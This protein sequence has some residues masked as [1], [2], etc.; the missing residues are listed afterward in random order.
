MKKI[1]EI[2]FALLVLLSV[3]CK[4]VNNKE[5][6]DNNVGITET[7]IEETVSLDTHTLPES[8]MA[9]D[10]KDIVSTDIDAIR[11]KYSTIM[12][13]MENNELEM[14]TI[15]FRCRTADDSGRLIRYSD[16]DELVMMEY[17]K[18]IGHAF[19]TERMYFDDGNLFFVFVE[20]GIWSP[21][22]PT[23]NDINGTVATIKETRYYIDSGEIIRQL[24]KSFK[25]RSWT[26]DPKSDEIPNTEVKVKSGTMYSEIDLINELKEGNINC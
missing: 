22:G 5:V 7:E 21:G 11:M 3:S 6:A 26:D 25:T 18:G 14:D 20:D 13:K 9:M 23:P 12:K 24:E 2:S 19:V 15:S 8:D 4:E 17:V 16:G 10:S 1:A